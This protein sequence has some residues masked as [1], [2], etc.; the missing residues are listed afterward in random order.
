LQTEKQG[1]DCSS[2]VFLAL[3]LD[4]FQERFST[5]YTADKKAFFFFFQNG[6]LNGIKKL[7]LF[8]KR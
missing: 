5:V 4:Y 3:R 1:N 6:G 7:D 2:P 8:T